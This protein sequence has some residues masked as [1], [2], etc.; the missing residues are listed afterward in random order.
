MEWLDDELWGDGDEGAHLGGVARNP[1]NPTKWVTYKG[2]LD[3]II[4]RDFDC[5]ARAVAALERAV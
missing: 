2:T 3:V 5:R 4:G 1:Y